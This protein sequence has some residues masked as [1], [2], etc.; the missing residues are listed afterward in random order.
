MM[1]HDMAHHLQL[2][3]QNMLHPQLQVH[4]V[5]IVSNMILDEQIFPD[6]ILIGW[7]LVIV[8]ALANA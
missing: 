3:Y 4:D 7:I 5:W 6:N 2:E 1:E 8:K